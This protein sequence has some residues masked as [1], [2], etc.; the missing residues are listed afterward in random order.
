M[1]VSPFLLAGGSA[2]VTGLNAWL[3]RHQ[4]TRLKKLEA[5]STISKN[6]ML[7]CIQEQDE[8]VEHI[9]VLYTLVTELEQIM[10]SMLSPVYFSKTHYVR[11]LHA[12]RVFTE[13]DT[14]VQW[15]DASVSPTVPHVTFYHTTHPDV[16]AFTNALIELFRWLE[17]KKNNR[18]AI[19]AFH[20]GPLHT[21]LEELSR[22]F[23]NATDGRLRVSL[24]DQI[25]MARMWSSYEQNPNMESKMG[26]WRR[27]LPSV[28]NMAHEAIVRE[29]ISD[30]KTYMYL[31]SSGAGR[32]HQM[33]DALV[34]TTNT[35]EP[36]ST[37][38]HYQFSADA[39][40][41]CGAAVSHNDVHLQNST[42]R[43]IQLTQVQVPPSWGTDL[44]STPFDSI[45][46]ADYEMRQPHHLETLR[47]TANHSWNE[48]YAPLYVGIHHLFGSLQFEKERFVSLGE[49]STFPEYSEVIVSAFV[50]AGWRRHRRWS[51]R[52]AYRMNLLTAHACKSQSPIR[53]SV[54]AKFI[55]QLCSS[56]CSKLRKQGKAL[57][58][59]VTDIQLL[60][61]RLISLFVPML[62]RCTI[63]SSMNECFELQSRIQTL[64]HEADAVIQ[65]DIRFREALMDNETA[66]IY[67][68]K[69][70]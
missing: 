8:A 20:R 14:T 21:A 13:Q 36:C 18:T 65:S 2:C 3:I 47:E 19:H 15:V 57:V 39:K 38:I 58:H 70:K 53:A 29:E 44:T 56:G 11:S 42:T 9:Y 68:N 64:I 5:R 40:E 31:D 46:Y 33:F 30:T 32:H 52:N 63:E 16:I 66:N 35:N 48:T 22:F 62:F 55:Q 27:C 45:V 34:D 6:E 17:K 61:I 69:E 50:K 54:R 37:A 41:S 24:L 43:F 7:K 67:H 4:S 51:I 12:A 25:R 1:D 49:G 60:L 59:D 10:T 28:P 23:H 26:R